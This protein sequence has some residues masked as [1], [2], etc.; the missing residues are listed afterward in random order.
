[1]LGGIGPPGGERIKRHSMGVIQSSRY[2]LRRDWFN[3]HRTR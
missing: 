2:A 3:S 1:M